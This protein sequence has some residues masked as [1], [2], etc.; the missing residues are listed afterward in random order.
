MILVVINNQLI[1]QTKIFK[2]IDFIVT[3][4]KQ[5]IVN[6]ISSI[7]L[8]IDNDKKKIIE[9]ENYWPGCLRLNNK[10]YADI[11]SNNLDSVYLS[12]T[13]IENSNDLY[14]DYTYLIKYNP[15]W[16][17][18]QY[19]ILNIYDLRDK[20]FRAKYNPLS[21]DKLYTFDIESPNFTFRRV[22]KNKNMKWK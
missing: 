9:A 19:C 11:L 10:D 13:I 20:K 12:I 5:I 14:N 16:L 2:D 15:L 21:K 18:D 7:K 4:N 3:I 6:D 1:G 22:E 8:I 17:T